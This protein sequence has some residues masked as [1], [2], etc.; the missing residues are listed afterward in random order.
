MF[1]SYQKNEIDT[2]AFEIKNMKACIFPTDTVIGIA[3]LDEPIL[4]KIKQRPK[5]KKIVLLVPSMS[6]L[7]KLNELQQKF[8]N[9]FWPGGVTVVHKGVSYRMPD[10]DWILLLLSKTGPLYC[11]SANISNQEVIKDTMEANQ[12]FDPKWHFSLI[13]VE[14]HQQSELPSTIVD[15]DNWKIL[16]QGCHYED[17]EQFLK[18][19]GVFHA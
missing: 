5:N 10:D 4:Y 16:R 13:L 1:R 6:A 15:I 2:I 17:I 19:Q 9:Q 11:S 3:A 14:G 18:T 7:G 12:V 8:L